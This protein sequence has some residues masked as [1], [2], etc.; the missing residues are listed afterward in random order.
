MSELGPVEIANCEFKLGLY[1]YLDVAI[2]DIKR[3]AS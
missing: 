3:G 1:S 2:C